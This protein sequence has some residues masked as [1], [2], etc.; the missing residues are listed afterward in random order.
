MGKI[1]NRFNVSSFVFGESNPCTVVSEALIQNK[2]AEEVDFL[3]RLLP[4]GTIFV[5][6]ERL[7]IVSLSIPFVLTFE[8]PMFEDGTEIQTDYVRTAW[9]DPSVPDH[10]FQGNL[11]LGIRY[12]RPDGTRMYDECYKK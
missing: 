2:I 5:S 1:I 11:F 9:I 3:L 10:L 4:K 12:I 6:Q 7:A 8:H